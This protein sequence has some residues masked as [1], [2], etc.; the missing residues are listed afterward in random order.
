MMQ[1]CRNRRA[2]RWATWQKNNANQKAIAEAGGIEKIVAAMAH[3]EAGLL[4][5]HQEAGM[6]RKWAS[7]AMGNI[8]AQV[9]VQQKACFALGMLAND[10]SANQAQIARAGGIE[11]VMAAMAAHQMAVELQQE[12]CWALRNLAADD[13]VAV[14][15]A[16]SGGIERVVVTMVAHPSAVQVQKCAC[17]ALVNLSQKKRSVWCMLFDVFLSGMF[18]AGER[19][20]YVRRIKTAGGVE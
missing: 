11:Q 3:Q 19:A 5:T 14:K 10:N 9:G 15:I 17:G 7:W 6:L 1:G 16:E 8:P 20:V 12:A 2:W 4:R 13:N 18:S